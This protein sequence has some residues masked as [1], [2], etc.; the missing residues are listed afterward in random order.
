[1]SFADDAPASTIGPLLAAFSARSG[2]ETIYL[3]PR[4][5]YFMTLR[6][7]WGGEDGHHPPDGLR[8]F[9]AVSL[10]NREEPADLVVSTVL[11]NRAAPELTAFPGISIF[12]VSAGEATQAELA[13]LALAAADS[14]GPLEGIILI[15]P[16]SNDRTAGMTLNVLPNGRSNQPAPLRTAAGSAAGQ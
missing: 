2:N 6:Q 10:G 8:A 1:M 13:R 11:V 15:N 4:E 5:D 7:A 9:E 14:G 16:L 12:S 3:S